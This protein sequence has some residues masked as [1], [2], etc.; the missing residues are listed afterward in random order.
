MKD[1]HERLAAH[2]DRRMRFCGLDGKLVTKTFPEVHADVRATVAWLRHAGL[3]A[4]DLVGVAGPNSYH[5]VVAD[6]ALLA[7]GCVPVA[8]AVEGAGGPSPVD[9]ADQYR[10]S[11]LLL[12]KAPKGV[13]ALPPHVAVLGDGQP[14]LRARDVERVELPGDVFTVAFSSGTSGSK[15]GLMMSAAGVMNTVEVSGEAWRLTGADDILIVMPFSNFQQRYLLYTALTY[16]VDVTVVAPERMFQMMKTLAPT[17]ILGPPSF[18]ELVENRVRGA[19][20]RDKVRYHVAA[21]LHALLPDAVGRGLR[22]RLGR[23][24]TAMFGDRV[25]LMFT[26][27]A[28]VPPSMVKT[29]HQLGKPLF[30]VYGSTEVGWIAMN[31]PGACRIGSAGLPV[32]G[33]RVELNDDGEVLVRTG[34]PQSLGYVFEGMETQPSVYL[35]DG[36]IATGDL[37]AVDRNG[38][39]RLVGRR[40]NVIITR[41]GVKINPEEL[42]QDVEKVCRVEK[43]VVVAPEA[44]GLLTC[45]VWLDDWESAD[46][47]G[48]IERQ[49]TAANARK[50]VAHRITRVVFRP[51]AELT[52]EN[53]LLTRNLKVDRT[54]V[55]RK[56]F[57]VPSGRER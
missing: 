26:G 31:L 16:G 15:K 37:A 10:L 20:R 28:P 46:R 5:W 47:T 33:L 30:E 34:R 18:F 51:A 39:L 21:V 32:P 50:D 3:G 14:T 41:S 38:F 43:A 2:P 1:L 29:F 4:G 36:R 48:E 27:S 23:T 13:E 35:E 24:W 42:E 17:I 19:S 52:V 44:N 45:V 25:R 56:V 8:L 11:A 40:K 6:L 53:G 55:M 22:A 12:T 7:I 9:L 57:A 49:I 54:A